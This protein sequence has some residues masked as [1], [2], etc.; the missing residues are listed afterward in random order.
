MKLPI[1]ISLV[2]AFY[3]VA[4]AQQAS[5][6]AGTW[7]APP[8]VFGSPR[9]PGF[10]RVIV[11]I[12]LAKPTISHGHAKTLSSAR[13]IAGLLGRVGGFDQDEAADECE[14]CFAKNF[15]LSMVFER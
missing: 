5:P 15:G 3:G 14:E 4:Q 1:V 9:Q 2:L 10:A 11:T 6:N 13:Y 8:K 12:R 7:R